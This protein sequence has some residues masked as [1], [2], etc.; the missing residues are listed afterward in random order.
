MKKPVSRAPHMLKS[1]LVYTFFKYLI[2][3]MNA[4]KGIL[5]A[6]YLGPALLGT[7]SLI[8]LGINYSKYANLGIFSAMNLQLSIS[9]GEPEKEGYVTEVISTT[10]LFMGV[11]AAFFIVCGGLAKWAL[12]QWIPPDILPY[13]WAMVFLCITM[14]IKNFLLVYFRIYHRFLLIN[15]LD[16]LG[17]LVILI[18]VILFAK[19]FTLD[20]VM[21]SSCVAGLITCC[22]FF[23]FNTRLSFKP[24]W[25]LL[26]TL[27]AIGLPLL[28]C[29]FSDYLFTTLDRVIIA[30]YFAREY[31]GYYAFGSTLAINS[32]VIIDAF[33]YLYYPKF[34][35]RFHRDSPGTPQEKYNTLVQYTFW[36]ETLNVAIGVAT[37]SAIRYVIE[38]FLPAYGPSILT[39]QILLLTLI[40]KSLSYFPAIYLVAN[41][42][43]DQILAILAILIPVSLGLMLATVKLGLGFK[44]VLLAN[45]AAFFLYNAGLT[46]LML[47]N[48]S[49]FSVKRLAACYGRYLIFSGFTL[50]VLLWH[51]DFILAFIPVFLL[52]YYK[53]LK[54]VLIEIVHRIKPA[55]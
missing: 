16:F 37:I 20:A 8:N 26:W 49:M 30:K 45:F 44:G 50:S 10:A 32:M 11:M 21:A 15:L 35:K 29:G 55:H 6:A 7:Y 34:L 47:K 22:F 51:K 24:N 54:Q 13:I 43:Q 9:H 42:R 5:M 52:L 39:T 1:S 4:V 33:G 19:S 23:F 17:N 36:L 14:Q 3:A 18:G 40:L 12:S 27:I 41:K 28:I 31:M 46:G 53:G 48:T 2:L 25:P 38:W